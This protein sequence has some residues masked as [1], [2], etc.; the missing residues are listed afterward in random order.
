VSDSV[1]FEGDP[2]TDSARRHLERVLSGRQPARR[3]WPWMVAAL[4]G[5]GLWLLWHSGR[6]AARSKTD[7]GAGPE[8]GTGNAGAG[9]DR[10]GQA[11]P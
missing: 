3:K 9:G 2:E 6:A 8:P 7:A 11:K 10:K 4:G 5:G 1:Y